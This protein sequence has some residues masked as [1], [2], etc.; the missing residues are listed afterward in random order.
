MKS[1]R[2]RAQM[3]YGSPCFRIARPASKDAGWG[4]Y[5]MRGRGLFVAEGS[6]AKST[7]TLRVGL[8]R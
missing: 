1:Y 6:C 8:G 2:S 3:V 5:G 7:G 4:M